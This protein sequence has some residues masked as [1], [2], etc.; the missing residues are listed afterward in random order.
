MA[1]ILDTNTNK[2]AAVAVG[3]WVSFKSD[4]EQSGL[5]VAIGN[6]EFVLENNQGFEGGYIGG[7]TIT[8]ALIEDCWTE[9]RELDDKGD[10]DNDF[11]R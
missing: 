5:I 4:V 9:Y 3:D 6:G 1:L 11:I 2:L 8:R 10:S 7:D